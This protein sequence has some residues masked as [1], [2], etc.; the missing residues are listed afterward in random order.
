MIEDSQPD[1]ELAAMLGVSIQF[2]V[3][4]AAI[5]A[6]GT[7]LVS[8]QA[9]S[10]RVRHAI[11]LLVLLR[12]TLPVRPLVAVRRGAGVSGRAAIGGRAA[13]GSYSLTSGLLVP[14]TVRGAGVGFVTLAGAADL[15]ARVR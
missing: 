15:E 8:A 7:V 14:S 6:D 2:T 9:L 5:V 10:P 4:W 13:G 11:W 1:T 3:A 12:L